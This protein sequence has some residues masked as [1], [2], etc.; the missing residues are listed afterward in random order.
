MRDGDGGSYNVNLDVQSRDDRVDA[1]F[2]TRSPSIECHNG[3]S[4]LP[5]HLGR[6]RLLAGTQVGI[7]QLIQDTEQEAGRL[8]VDTQSPAGAVCAAEQTVQAVGEIGATFPPLVV[9]VEP[10]EQA[11]LGV[12]V[13]AHGALDASRVAVELLPREL[14]DGGELVLQQDDRQQQRVRPE[15]H[16][17]VQPVADAGVEQPRL[18]LSSGVFDDRVGAFDKGRGAPRREVI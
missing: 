11:G 18:V 5:S 2:E 3:V 16:T 9:R 10:A 8:P 15:R 14:T 6:N 7:F 13:E 17:V 12:V 1:R 4:D